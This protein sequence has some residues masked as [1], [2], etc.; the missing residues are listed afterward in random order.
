MQHFRSPFTTLLGVKLCRHRR[1]PLSRRQSRS[2]RPSFVTAAATTFYEVLQVSK[3]ADTK[4][5]KKA[6]KKMA[7]KY[8][9]DVNNEVRIVQG[10]VQWHTKCRGFGQNFYG[11]V[12]MVICGDSQLLGLTDTRSS[13][14]SSAAVL[15]DLSSWSVCNHS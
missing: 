11:E 13:S 4:T 8:H 15:G 3:D 12:A 6:F 5:I 7:L 2:L 1:K 10:C 9:P 14:P